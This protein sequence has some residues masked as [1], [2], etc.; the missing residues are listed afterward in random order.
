M[1]RIRSVYLSLLFI[2]K[3]YSITRWSEE[4][5][6]SIAK[7]EERIVIAIASRQKNMLC[8]FGMILLSVL[9]MEKFYSSF[10]REP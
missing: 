3:K 4:T 6:R 7:D 10:S 5:R 1:K 9:E 8:T 2:V